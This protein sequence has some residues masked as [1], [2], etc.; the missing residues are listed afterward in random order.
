MQF[1]LLCIGRS[2][3]TVVKRTMRGVRADLEP[4]RRGMRL[5]DSQDGVDTGLVAL[6]LSPE[7]SQNIG[8]D[9]HCGG[10]LGRPVVLAA[11]RV[12]PEVIGQAKI[13]ACDAGEGRQFA[14]RLKCP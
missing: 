5:R 8:V 7:P 11:H 13:A 4:H 9:S 12:L 3:A 1:P 6:T 2:A 14:Q 10:S